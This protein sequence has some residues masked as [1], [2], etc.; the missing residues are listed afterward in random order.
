MFKE[1]S[2]VKFWK[3]FSID[4]FDIFFNQNLLQPLYLALD[5]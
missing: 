2:A 3:L 5:V 4:V 1:K